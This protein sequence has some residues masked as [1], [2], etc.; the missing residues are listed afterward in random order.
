MEDKKTVGVGE[1]SL[2]QFLEGE[3]QTGNFSAVGTDILRKAPE[4][5]VNLSALEI[6]GKEQTELAVLEQ[7]VQKEDSPLEDI[8]VQ[9]F[10]ANID[11]SLKDVIDRVFRDSTRPIIIIRDDKVEYANKTFLQLL[12]LN[13]ESDVLNER[14]LKFVFKEDWNL[15]AENIGEML[16]NGKILTIRLRNFENKILKVS[17]SAVYVQDNQ[18]FS[19]ILVGEQLLQKKVSAVSGLYDGLTGLPNFYLLEDRI[20]VAVNN[21]NY[22]DVR[23][24]RSMIALLGIAIDNYAA[25]KTIGMHELV[26]KKLA[27][28]LALSLKKTYTVASGL[29]YQFWVLIPEVQSSADLNVEI[30]RVKAIFDEPVADNF[31]EHQ[32]VASIGVSVFP[33]PATSAKK[34]IEQ[35]IMAVRKAQKE[36][37]NKVILFGA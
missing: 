33:D 25:L 6:L 27:E 14:F 12:G 37:G 2:R 4:F 24:K 8:P 28:K 20:Q 30:Q 17:F 13:G 35:A 29:K 18:H 34:L 26:L 21:E 10:L 31:T 7:S 5:N 19:F 15:L 3:P 16:T 32:I 22:K 23:Q 36:G 11:V 1:D 9:T